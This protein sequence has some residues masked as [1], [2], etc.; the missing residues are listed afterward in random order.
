MISMVGVRGV[1]RV[2]ED[3]EGVHEGRADDVT[4]TRSCRRWKRREVCRNGGFDG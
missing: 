2:R 3:H 4:F 1:F